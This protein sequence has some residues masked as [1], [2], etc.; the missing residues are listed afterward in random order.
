MDIK[1]YF[2]DFFN[3]EPDLIDEYGAINISLVNDLPL[4]IDPFLLFK[5]KKKSLRKYIKK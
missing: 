3:V 4:F 2:S 1:V 5:A